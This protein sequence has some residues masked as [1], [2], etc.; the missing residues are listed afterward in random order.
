MEKTIKGTNL[1]QG[2]KISDLPAYKSPRTI[3]T[4]TNVDEELRILTLETKGQTEYL[5]DED[6][7]IDF[8][9]TN[10]DWYLV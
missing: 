9:I 7:C 10:D 5:V 1:K 4:V 6:G 3:F 2:D 8:L